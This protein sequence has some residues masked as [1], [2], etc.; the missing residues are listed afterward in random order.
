MQLLLEIGWINDAVT[1]CAAG[2]MPTV[3]IGST[4]TTLAECA[5][6]GLVA[7]VMV[8][9]T[10]AVTAFGLA[11]AIGVLLANWFPM[12]TRRIAGSFDFAATVGVMVVVVDIWFTLLSSDTD[13]LFGSFASNFTAPHRIG[14]DSRLSPFAYCVWRTARR[15]FACVCKFNCSVCDNAVYASS[16]RNEYTSSSSIKSL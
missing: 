8:R 9:N 10:D 2:D 3:D 15:S 13:E 1:L 12:E 6:N 14:F 11:S 4:P 16:W 7:G 5:L